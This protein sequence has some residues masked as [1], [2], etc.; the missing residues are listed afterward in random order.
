M[1]ML[2]EYMPA[3]LTPSQLAA[4]VEFL[5]KRFAEQER[6]LV[7]VMDGSEHDFWVDSREPIQDAVQAALADKSLTPEQCW[8]LVVDAVHKE[9]LPYA[10][11]C[12]MDV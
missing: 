3:E 11:E 9:A 5:K 7:A 8:A 1:N 4:G 6:A 12:A 2:T 10:S